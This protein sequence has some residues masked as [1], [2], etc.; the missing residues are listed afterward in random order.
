MVVVEVVV[1]VVV[2]GSVITVVGLT[3][4][5]GLWVVTPVGGTVIFV[6]GPAVAG[7]QSHPEQSQEYVVS[8]VSQVPTKLSSSHDLSC[9]PQ[10]RGQTDGSFVVGLAAGELTIGGVVVV[11]DFGAV[12][13]G[14]TQTS[15]KSQQPTT[16]RAMDSE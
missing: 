15:R 12:E 4:V 2:G 1:V 16:T 7:I 6:V 8:N 3:G 13:F 9:V 11:V 5:V 14:A 10:E